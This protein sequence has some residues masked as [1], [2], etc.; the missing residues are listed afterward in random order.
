M[1]VKGV[2]AK[3]RSPFQLRTSG[4][5][6]A[7]AWLVAHLVNLAPDQLADGRRVTPQSI[8]DPGH[9]GTYQEFYLE[10]E[11]GI[12]HVAEQIAGRKT[13]Q[14][15][16]PSCVCAKKVRRLRALPLPAAVSVCQPSRR[17]D[18]ATQLLQISLAPKDHRC[19][20]QPTTTH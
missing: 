9:G 7:L 1:G 10:D 15:S 6:T 5:L 18:G 17:P 19:A 4:P 13:P 8:N 20:M 16:P 14:V 2:L 11:Q 12:A 3:F